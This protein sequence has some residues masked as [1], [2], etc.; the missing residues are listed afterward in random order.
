[1]IAARFA[2]RREPDRA[3]VVSMLRSLRALPRRHG[4][5]WTAA[6][7]GLAA[8]ACRSEGSQSRAPGAP[9]PSIRPVEAPARDGDDPREFHDVMT[10]L[11]DPSTRAEAIADINAIVLAARQDQRPVLVSILVPAFLE[12]WEHS[13]EQRLAMLRVSMLLHHDGAAPLWSRAIGLDGTASAFH[14]TLLALHCVRSNRTTA[15]TRAVVD[16]LREVLA[17]PQ[18]DGGAQ[19]GGM[20]LEL[21]RTLQALGGP[22]AVAILISVLEQPVE[23]QPVEV[24]R[25]AAFALGRLRAAEAVD[26]LL[27]VSLRVPDVLS[28]TNISE[29]AKEALAAIGEPAAAPTLRML[30]GEHDGVEQ[31]AALHGLSPFTVEATAASFLGV[32]GSTSAVDPLLARLPRDGCRGERGRA[33]RADDPGETVS[34][35]T[36]IAHTLGLLGDA[37]AVEPLC[38]CA[39]ASRDPGDMYPIAEAL[40]RIGGPEATACLARVV[41]KA[42]YDEDAVE[43]GYRHELR[44]EGARFLIMAASPDDVA[45][46]EERLSAPKRPPKVVERQAQWQ[47]GLESLRRCRR[48]LPCWLA[49]LS[50]AEAPWF[51]RELAAVHAARIGRGDPAVAHAIATAFAVVD[52]DARTTMAWLVRHT[53]PD[54]RCWDCVY[55]LER[56]LKLGMPS[57]QYQR[58]MLEARYTI[59]RMREP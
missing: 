26:A 1:M 35:R 18:L 41:S 54:R 8:L 45:L 55:A 5:W 36:V 9:A 17:R 38:R 52:P 22:E 31:L 51:V 57:V 53:L 16:A 25:E 50:D 37:R 34:R 27:M 11:R 32:I 28:T 47:P 49:V 39:T 29:R 48:E 2:L 56:T 12:I 23:Q 7:L 3:I 24:H 44:W 59:A 58:S 6:L 21:V 43:P 46:I 30:A 33:S 40:G 13:P 20:R 10:R 19:S 15:S 4:R 14:A 42:T